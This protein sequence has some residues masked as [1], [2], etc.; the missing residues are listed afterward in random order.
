MNTL[1]GKRIEVKV[2]DHLSPVKVDVS[3]VLFSTIVIDTPA[4]SGYLQV[5]NMVQV[6]FK[7]TEVI[8][9]RGSDHQVSLRNQVN[10]AISEIDQGVLLSKVVV[11]TDIGPITSIITSG[12]IINL[13]LKLGD[14]VAAMI[15]TNEIM[16]S[17]C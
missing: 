11:S 1:T 9:G 13:N 14:K 7:E 6:I 15:K 17:S 8:I 5:D 3:G 10:G 12:A 4:S 2:E 16:L